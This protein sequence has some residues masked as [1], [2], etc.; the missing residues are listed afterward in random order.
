LEGTIKKSIR[1]GKITDKARLAKAELLPYTNAHAHILDEL[2]WLNRLL[3][4]HVLRLRQVNFYEG[5]R[6][7][8]HFFIDDEEIDAL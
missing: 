3:A 2:R 7:F 1:K 6:D 4:A 5:V 8:R